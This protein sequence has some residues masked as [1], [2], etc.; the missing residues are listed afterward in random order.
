MKHILYAEGGDGIGT[1]HL[2]RV[3]NLIKALN[4]KE[5]YL[6]CYENCIQKSFYLEKNIPAISLLELKQK[7]C[8]N[9][10]FIDTKKER[11]DLIKVFKNRYKKLIVID[12]STKL[13]NKAD[14]QITPSYYSKDQE[15]IVKETLYCS[16]YKYLILNPDINEFHW[17]PKDY[18]LISFGGEDPNNLTLKTLKILKEVNKTHNTKVVLGPN[19]K[20]DKNEILNYI[21]AKDIYENPGNL[22]EMFS[23]SLYVIT[24]L[25]VTLQELFKMSVPSI[26]ITNY[27]EDSFEF[28][29]IEKYAIK[30]MGKNFINFLGYHKNINKNKYLQMHRRVS[31]FDGQQ[32]KLPLSEIGLNLPNL[33]KFIDI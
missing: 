4:L 22:Y 21:E 18:K 20:H 12:N 13:A 27:Y 28:E 29:I 11:L 6:C 14:I 17:N 16:G 1:G 31:V 5:N 15:T 33:K 23:H 24:A 30:Y 2:N 7:D 3:L 19:Y 32:I 10:F 8:F 25:G 26:V 9:T